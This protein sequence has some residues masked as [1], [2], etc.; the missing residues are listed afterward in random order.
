[1]NI[2]DQ[3]IKCSSTIFSR[4]NV[5]NFKNTF[6]YLRSNIILFSTHMLSKCVAYNIVYT[7]NNNNFA[8]LES[9]LKFCVWVH[10]SIHFILCKCEGALFLMW[11]VSSAVKWLHLM[12]SMNVYMD[13]VDELFSGINVYVCTFLV[14]LHKNSFG[15]YSPV[16]QNA[17][18]LYTHKI[19]YY[20][21]CLNVVSPITQKCYVSLMFIWISILCRFM[22][23]FRIDCSVPP[24]LH[25]IL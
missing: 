5:W 10:R 6:H 13:D 25:T 17:F 3:T 18:L 11:F 7:W 20:Y 9:T 24:K 19:L 4:S 14:Y 2:D 15:D 21:P 12:H 16:I 23:S 22:F 1:M 8:G